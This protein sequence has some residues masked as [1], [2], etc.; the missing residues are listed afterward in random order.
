M[1]I[2][3]K[4]R[5]FANAWTV[6][7]DF[8]TF[9]NRQ[10]QYG[11]SLFQIFPSYAQRNV[12]L[13]PFQFTRNLG[14]ELYPFSMARLSVDE[15]EAHGFLEW[16]NKAD[17]VSVGYGT[18]IEDTTDIKTDTLYVSSFHDGKKTKYWGK[19]GRI[20][21]NDTDKITQDL[22]TTDI[23]LGVRQ[24]VKKFSKGDIFVQAD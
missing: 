9:A 14:A 3:K 15:T 19:V 12:F 21:T 10:L 24:R 17:R 11:Y 8:P 5:L 13:S 6:E 1:N 20:Q 18:R 22:G 23:L 4:L 7:A 16:E 2:S